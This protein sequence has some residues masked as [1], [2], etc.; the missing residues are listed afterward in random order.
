MFDLENFEVY[1]IVN[2]SAFILGLLFGAIA[3]KNQFCFSGS[4]KDYILTN[5]TKRAASVVM[6]I[7]V[8]ILSTY[9]VSNIN[10]IDLS[11]S[12]YLKENV[13]YFAIILGGVLFGIGMMIADGC[14][15]RH[16]VKFAQ[17]D[18]YSLVTLVFIAIFAFA[19]TRGFVNEYITLITKNEMLLSLSSNIS[20][21][22]LNIFIVVVPLFIFLWILTKSFSRILSLKDGVLMGLLVAAGWY[23]TG[24]IGVESIERE[25]NLT[26]VTFVYPTA[27]TL[28]FFSF[29][30]V[31][32]LSFGVSVILGV[33]SGA[34][35]MSKFNRKYSFGCTSNLQ[36]SKVKYN[37]IGGALMGVG[38]VL[39]I[40]CTVG[41]GLTGISTLAFASVLAI[42]SIMISGFLTAKYLGKQDK[43][44]MCFIFEWDDKKEDEAK[45]NFQI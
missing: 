37:M 9:F 45:S 40:G 4:I 35:I 14:S 1:E 25:I 7:I 8:A 44:P 20:N 26:S 15:S 31:T 30:Q 32:E 17:G 36:H 3:Q 22:P 43:L 21:S 12:I 11:E 23:M 39:A 33:V 6:A 29:F 27:Q 34:F 10:E 41:Q 16:L 5:S 42:L 28:E 19:T 2:I 38:G 13:N 18:A 24:V